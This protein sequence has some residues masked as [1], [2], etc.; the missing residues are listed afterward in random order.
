MGLDLTLFMTDWEHLRAIPVDKRIEALDDIWSSEFDEEYR[1]GRSAGGWLWPAD[2][3][4][5]WCAEYVFFTTTGA[6]RPHWR[7]GDG[8]ADMRLLLDASVREAMDTFLAGLIWDAD[9]ADDPA[10]TGGGGFFPP[11]ADPRY[12]CV[13][14][15]C[16]PEAVPGKARAWARV[17]SRLEELR[18][19]FAAECEGWAGRPDTFEDFTALLR[20]WGGVTTEAAR[21]GWGLVG[22]P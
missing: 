17:E 22:L 10:L 21:R 19:P 16:P 4:S 20:E 14:L 13:L 11:T 9:P 3:G 1:R 7:A 2:Q 6:Y 15:V 5:A 18:E 8:W 12:P